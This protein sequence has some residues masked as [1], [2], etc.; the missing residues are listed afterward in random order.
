MVRLLTT[1]KIHPF[2]CSPKQGAAKPL[3]IIGVEMV[4][5]F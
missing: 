1:W 4:S 5:M 2:I 3:S